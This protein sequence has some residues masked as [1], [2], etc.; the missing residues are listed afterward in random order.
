[1]HMLVFNKQMRETANAVRRSCPDATGFTLLELLVVIAV[2]AVVAVLLFPAL[3]RA[4]DRAQRTSCMSNLKQI[5]MG[6]RMYTD[7]FTDL[8]PSTPAAN[9]GPS[10]ANF[11]AVTGY[12]ELMK[13]NVGLKGQSS[14]Q[15]KVFACPSD[16]FYFDAP[17][18]GHVPHGFHEQAFTDYSSYAFNAGG[19]NRLFGTMGHG[20]AGRKVA[21]IKE[22]GRTLLLVEASA[23]F[24]FS[25]HEPKR[26]ISLQNATFRDAKNVVSFVDGHADY[27]KIFWNTNRIQVGGSSYGLMASDFD[28]PAEYAYKWKAD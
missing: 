22:P 11:I 4:K 12:K 6:L 15:D 7:D 1:L 25:W 10:M 16:T 14:P 20:L 21:S 24:P 5:N 28:P 13:A 8:A 26:P 2:V 19:T 17:P 3:S 27:L 23:L 18:A 9:I